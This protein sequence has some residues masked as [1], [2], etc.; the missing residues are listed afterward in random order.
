LNYKHLFLEALE[1]IK[2]NKLRVFL[3]SAII[4]IGISSLVGILTSIDGIKSSVSD[5]FSDLGSNIYTIES[6]RNNRGRSSGLRKKNQPPIRYRQAKEFTKKYEGQGTPTISTGVTGTAELKYKSETTNPN[7]FIEAGDENFILVENIILQNGRNFTK[8]ENE[9]GI[10]V[11]LIGSKIKSALFKNNEDPINK[12]IT[13]RGN[14]FRV[15]GILE[16]KGSS[17]GGGGDNRIIIPIETARKLRP[18]SNYDITVK[19]EDVSLIEND[20]DYSTNLF[21]ILRKDPIGGALSF[22]IKKNESLDSE[23]DEIEGYLKYGG[24]TIGFITLIGASIGLMNIMLV[25]VSERTREIGLRKSIGATPKLIRNQFLI[26]SILIC[27]FGGIGGVLFGLIF[28]NVVTYLIGGSF[29]VPWLWVFLGI[30]IS[31]IVGMGSGYIPARKASK[32]DPIES[33]RFE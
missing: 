27:Q 4:S 29:I 10:F 24:F 32:L 14:K 12:Y 30:F 9:S 11:T 8:I 16:E 22:E 26:E 19:I 20:M 2:S 7:V 33:L 6:E 31:T 17:F 5:S 3:T 18:T 1:S 21:K 25:S 15:I 28:G 23:L 13:A